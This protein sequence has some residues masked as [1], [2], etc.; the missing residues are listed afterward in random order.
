MILTNLC[1]N[2]WQNLRQPFTN[3]QRSSNKF[4]GCLSRFYQLLDHIFSGSVSFHCWIGYKSSIPNVK[5][6]G[7][8]DEV[9]TLNRIKSSSLSW[10]NRNFNEE[11]FSLNSKFMWI[12]EVHNSS[13]DGNFINYA[14]DTMKYE[15]MLESPLVQ[16]L[17]II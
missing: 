8:C 9:R 2:K 5:L 10:Y 16:H 3:E 15:G 12:S 11:S 7:K 1:N 4:P 6:S 13:R 17:H 14:I